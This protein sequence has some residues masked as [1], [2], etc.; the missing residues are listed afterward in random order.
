MAQQSMVNRHDRTRT[1]RLKTRGRVGKKVLAILKDLT[2]DPVDGVDIVL[3]DDDIFNWNVMVSGPQDS[4]YSDGEFSVAIKFNSQFPMHPPAFKMKTPIY[5]MNINKAGSICLNKIT[6]WSQN[7]EMRDILNDIVDLLKT[8]SLNDP[9][10]TQL[11]V[12]FQYDQERY[13]RN[14]K[15][16]TQMYAQGSGYSHVPFD[17]NMFN[18]VVNIGSNN[19]SDAVSNNNNGNNNNS[20]D[21]DDDNDDDNNNNN[22]TN[23]NNVNDVTESDEKEINSRNSNLTITNLSPDATVSVLVERECKQTIGSEILDKIVNSESPTDRQIAENNDF[24]CIEGIN[25]E[26]N[27]HYCYDMDNARDGVFVTCINLTAKQIT[28]EKY[29]MRSE[30][31]YF[32]NNELKKLIDLK[33]MCDNKANA[34]N[35]VRIDYENDNTCNKCLTKHSEVYYCCYRCEKYALCSSCCHLQI[36]DKYSTILNDNDTIAALTEFSG[37]S[38]LEPPKTV[39][40]ALIVVLGVGVYNGDMIDLPGVTKDY[41]NIF[42]VFS[43]VWKYKVFYW[44]NKHDNN[45]NNNNNNNDNSSDD[46][47]SIYTN[48]EKTIESNLNFKLEWNEDEISNFVEQVRKYIVKYKHDALIFAISGHGDLNKVLIDSNGEEYDLVS[49]YSMFKPYANGQLESYKEEKSESNCLFHIPKIFCIDICRGSTKAKITETDPIK[50]KELMKKDAEYQL[51]AEKAEK[52]AKEAKENKAK[53]A[54]NEEKEEKEEKQKNEKEQGKQIAKQA[55]KNLEENKK[56]FENDNDNDNADG[57][58]RESFSPKTISKEAAKTLAAEDAN[59]CMLYANTESHVVADGSEKGGL[60]LRNLVKLFNDKKFV[61]EH[62]WITMMFKIREYTKRDATTIGWENFTQ[63]VENEGTLERVVVFAVNVSNDDPEDEKEEK[64]I[65]EEAGMSFL[66]TNMSLTDKI[67][68]LVDR[69]KTQDDRADV[70][71]SLI[72][73]DVEMDEKLK[74]L[75]I[76]G[77]ILIDANGHSEKFYQAWEQVYITAINVNEDEVLWENEQFSD[78]YLYFYNEDMCRLQN[79]KPKCIKRHKLAKKTNEE[80]YKCNSCQ[81]QGTQVRYICHKCDYSLCEHCTNTLVCNKKK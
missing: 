76:N 75:K 15:L 58:D 36:C 47:K 60:F 22:S 45:N 34:H 79:M 56:E 80:S 30:H 11:A 66:V 55:A 64:H 32:I 14:A 28:H 39:S 17:L 44:V 71:K 77:F 69:E 12:L 52:K 41:E 51:N 5:H 8:P 40:N 74:L 72:S 23:N 49:I 61:L 78:N 50:A 21:N 24:V 70:I 63:I 18:N 16:C 6:N 7:Y 1:K 19:N 57:N 26:E 4:P 10:V 25:S 27:N 54:E 46:H 35:L 3:V 48:D 13:N 68:I 73:S 53:E 33:P 62:D 37:V 2:Q 29:F 67:A 9:L 38:S 43:K 65:E 42:R 20:D 81:K 59:F 31:L